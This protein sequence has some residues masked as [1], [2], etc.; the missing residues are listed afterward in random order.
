MSPP[1]AAIMQERM[2]TGVIL[3][4]KFTPQAFAGAIPPAVILTK[5]TNSTQK[6][7]IIFSLKMKKKRTREKITEEKEANFFSVVRK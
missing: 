3:A 5:I 6:E 4:S 7:R 1:V 2:T